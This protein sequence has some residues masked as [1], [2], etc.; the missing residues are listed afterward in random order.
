MVVVSLQPHVEFG[1]N[2]HWED[3]PHFISKFFEIIQVTKL[4][5]GPI[6]YWGW[7]GKMYLSTLIILLSEIENFENNLISNFGILKNVN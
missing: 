2:D 7:H 3:A 6:L 1:R 5:F 4:K